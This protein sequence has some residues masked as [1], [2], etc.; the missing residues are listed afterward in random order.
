MTNGDRIRT[1]SNAQL[2]C[3]LMCPVDNCLTFDD[4]PITIKK[5]SG[6]CKN[7]TAE[8]CAE[9]IYEWLNQQEMK[10]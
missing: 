9:C 2:A 5:D 4:E 8:Q 3:S 7:A 1:F 6:K 10:K